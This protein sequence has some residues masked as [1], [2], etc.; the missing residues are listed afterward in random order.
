MTW[1]SI[2]SLFLYTR[3]ISTLFYSPFA[4]TIA[5]L[6]LCIPLKGKISLNKN[7]LKCLNAKKKEIDH[8]STSSF[9]AKLTFKLKWVKNLFLLQRTRNVMNCY[10]HHDNFSQVL[11]TYKYYKT[12]CW[13]MN[14]CN[15]W[16]LIDFSFN[17]AFLPTR[18]RRLWFCFVSFSTRSLVYERLWLNLWIW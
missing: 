17:L 4:G 14:V 5:E 10:V 1:K 16:I 8:I 12:L 6:N 9:H 7:K 11:R 2:M 18:Y 13:L 15:N 3:I